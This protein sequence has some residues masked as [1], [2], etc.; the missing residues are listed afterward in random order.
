MQKMMDGKGLITYLTSK[1]QGNRKFDL[2][3]H[4]EVSDGNKDLVGLLEE[5]RDNKLDLLVITDHDTAKVF[6]PVQN[7]EVNPEDY[8]VKM[9]TG[10][11]VTTLT[12][13]GMVETL[14]YGFDYAKY[15][16]YQYAKES[17]FRYLT[18]EFKLK[19]NFDIFKHLPDIDYSINF[20]DTAKEINYFYNLNKK[21]F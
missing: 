4:S 13:H 14:M 17:D 18:R 15:N 10:V 12:E 11:E 8:G 5:A 19:R 20:F 6:E 16:E 1:T 9:T 3:C 2:H 21:K 7:G